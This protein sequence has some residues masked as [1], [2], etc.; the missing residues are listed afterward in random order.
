[1]SNRI[2]EFS[3]N[4][5]KTKTVKSKGESTTE[6]RRAAA[7][8]KRKA[9]EKAQLEAHEQ[10]IREARERILTELANNKRIASL[11]FKTGLCYTL[12]GMALCGLSLAG[13]DSY[14]AVLTFGGGHIQTWQA[15][16]FAVIIDGLLAGAKFGMLFSSHTQT[17]QW[18]LGLVSV[19]ITSSIILNFLEFASTYQDW[20]PWIGHGILGALVPSIVLISSNFIGHLWAEIQEG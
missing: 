16:A 14:H 5:A 4:G 18:A 10:L 3:T 15:V 13:Y 11:K 6:D 9:K 7:L 17:K 12:A 20:A 2:A 1:M 19:G 8:V